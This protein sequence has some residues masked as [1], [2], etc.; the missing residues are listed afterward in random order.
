MGKDEEG[1]YTRTEMPENVWRE[2]Q[3]YAL[4]VL[5]L[6]ES[7]ERIP[8]YPMLDA[9]EPERTIG[10]L[11]PAGSGAVYAG[12]D[13]SETRPVLVSDDLVQSIVARSLHLGAVNSQA[14][15]VELLRSGAITAEEYSSKI[16][17]LVLMNYWLVRISADDILRRL[18]ASGY[19][20]TPGTQVM[21][22]TL[23]GPDC[24]ED[25]AA[26]VGAEVIA[27]LAKRPLIPEHLDVLLSLVIAAIRRGR[28]TNQVLVK[29]KSGIASRLRL[30]P[31]QSARILQSVDF[32]IQT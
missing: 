18:E 4:S 19:R 9:D 32:Y 17:E 10:A 24:A 11:T 2:R 13:Q 7:L 21:L 8:S 16:E 31:L 28:H 6:A 27:T 25:T 20:T 30:A 14:L 3:E 23:W 26:F 1:R 5:E 12:D 22:R 29:F 15:L